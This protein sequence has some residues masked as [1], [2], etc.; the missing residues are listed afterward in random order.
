MDVPTPFFDVVNYNVAYGLS[1]IFVHRY[2][3]L[4][5]KWM[6]V[7]H[8]NGKRG[9]KRY[10]NNKGCDENMHVDVFKLVN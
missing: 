4:V 9:H 3:N 8:W 6:G 2:L 10:V 1:R 5:Q 7:Y